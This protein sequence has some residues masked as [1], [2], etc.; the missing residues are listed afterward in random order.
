MAEALRV[1]A[2][3]GERDRHH[4]RPLYTAIV[5]AAHE[6]G[7]AGATAFKG[8]EGYGSHWIEH[9]ARVVDM[10]SD[11]PVVVEIIDEPATIEAFLPALTAMV[12]AGLITLER[13][14][15]VHRSARKPPA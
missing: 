4:G 14:E 3:V 6:A 15:V 10:S 13:I 8:I 1:R 12:G 9:S 5:H 7:L 11:L 2:Y